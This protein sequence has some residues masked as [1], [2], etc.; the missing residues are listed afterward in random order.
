MMIGNIFT[1]FRIFILLAFLALPAASCSQEDPPVTDP[2]EEPEKEPEKPVGPG[3]E[4]VDPGWETAETAVANM[5]VGWNL[6]NTLDTYMDNGHDGSDW[7]YWE[8]GWGQAVT[9][10]ELM[11]MMKN[12]G[13]GAIRV[14]VT[15]GVH[16]DA[17]GKVYD[18]WMNRVHQVVDYVL[19]AGMYCIINIHHDTGADKGAWLIAG[20]DEYEGCRQRY[21]YLWKQ[22]AEEFAA[23]D[24]RLLF[25]SYNEMLDS[26]RSWCYAS[27][28]GAYDAAFAKDAYDAI[29]AYAQS[30]VDVVR[31][32]KGNNIARNL[33]V[34]TYGACSG[35]GTWNQHLKDPL[36]YMELPEDVLDDHIIFQVHA[37]PGIEDMNAMKTEVD[38]MFSALKT[39]LASKGAPVIIGEWGTSTQNPSMES[40]LEFAPYFVSRS[41]EYGMGTFFWMGL[42]DASARSFPAFTQPELAEAIVK[43]YHGE[44]HSGSYPRMDDYDCTYTVTYSSQWSEL[45][46]CGVSIATEDYVGIRFVL[47]NE[48]GEGNLAVKIY[49]ETDDKQTYQHFNSKEMMIPFDK[50][51]SG[52]RINRITLQY[53]KTGVFTIDVVDAALIRTDGR[54]EKTIINPFWGCSVEM[55]AVPKS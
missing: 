31:G 51:S 32:T 26:R 12:A 14:P 50:S 13:F 41:M 34:N 24:H 25:E 55:E 38:D 11:V 20:S 40:L 27:F 37:Y 2:V 36:K 3:D 35:A 6:G 47:G 15:W 7:E 48:P 29:N 42:S 5:G 8:T 28:N 1:Y 17:S 46:L 45:N 49:G 52:S 16:T 23:Y 33:I 21:E 18:A 54:E 22:I 10:P 44:S 9:K 30:F 53:M 4:V 19:D 39:H 43:T